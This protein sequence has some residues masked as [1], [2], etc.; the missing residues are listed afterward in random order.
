MSCDCFML[1]TTCL[2]MPRSHHQVIPTYN[3]YYTVNLYMNLGE[4][5][6]FLSSGRK[7]SREEATRKTYTKYYNGSQRNCFRACGLD[8]SLDGDQGLA[9]VNTVTSFRVT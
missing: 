9:V 8:A 5:I 1:V 4:F 2:G 3:A 6:L 7:I